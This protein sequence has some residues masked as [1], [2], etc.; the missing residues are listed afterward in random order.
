MENLP[1]SAF[2]T[3]T[4]DVDF[5]STRQ[6][7]SIA[8]GRRGIAP[9][10][11]GRFVGPRLNGT[12]APGADWFVVQHDGSLLID[13]RLTLE[14]DDG[15]SVYLSYT[16]SMR[17]RGDAMARFARG[18]LLDSSEYNLIIHA[19]LEC[20]DERY[21]WLNGLPVVGVGKQTATGPVYSLFAIGNY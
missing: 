19:K 15:V 20:G 9:V 8:A 1:H 17:G 18:E 14:T 12:V 13:V 21:R 5:A 11:G 10:T 2:L 3:L 6:I 16:G 7:G 4:L